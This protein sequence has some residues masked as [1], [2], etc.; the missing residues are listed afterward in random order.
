MSTDKRWHVDI[1]IDEHDGRTRAEARLHNPGESELVGAGMARR[2][3]RDQEV[4]EIGDEL[5]VARALSDLAHKLLDAT[6]ADIEKI[7]HRPAYL[8]E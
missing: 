2:N 5:A 4:P 1:V 7:T 3:P 8:A 6:A